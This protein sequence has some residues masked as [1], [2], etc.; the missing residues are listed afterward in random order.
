LWG[1]ALGASLIGAPL[2]ATLTSSALFLFGAF[3]LRSAGCAINDM[4]DQDFDKNVERCKDRPL[5]AGILTNKEAFLFTGAHLMGGLFILSQLTPT[6][7]YMSLGIFPVACLYP[8][9]KRYTHYA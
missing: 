9:A 6:A 2:T 1:T 7:I 5:A 8:L 3:N 4:W